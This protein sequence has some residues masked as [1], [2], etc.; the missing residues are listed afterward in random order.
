MKISQK[1]FDRL[2]ASTEEFYSN[3]NDITC[4][5]LNSKVY[6]TSEGF[7]HLRY[8]KKK[9][10]TQE[11]QAAKFKLVKK[12]VL[13]LQKTTTI[14]EY[15]ERE[16][17]IHKKRNK[18]LTKAWS[19]VGYWGFIAIIGGTRLKVVV[20]RIDN[21]KYLFWSVI[22]VWQVKQFQGTRITDNSKGNLAED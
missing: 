14:Q 16:E 5:A 18:K 17:E 2:K 13:L 1:E 12:A 20:R 10:R 7:H 11:A 9:A 22:P 6:F 8:S 4:P 15:S 19:V 21:G 3:V